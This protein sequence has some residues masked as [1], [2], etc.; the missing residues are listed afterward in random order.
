MIKI[1]S[2][3][4]Y[5]DTTK[6]YGDCIIF[7]D[8]AM[9][10]VYDCGSTEHAN[11][12]IEVLD[13][14][15]IEKATLVLSH[16]DDDH[17]LGIPTLIEAGR[18]DKLFTVLLLKYK[19]ELLD[20]IDDGRRNDDSIARAITD[21][22]DNITS[23]SKKVALRDVYEDE[24]E[25]PVQM[26]RIGPSFDYMI[27]AA[28]RGLDNREGNTIDNETITNAASVQIELTLG[29]SKV[30]LTGDCAPAAIPDDVQ[31]DAYGYIQLPHHG[32]PLLAEEIFLRT[33]DSND[34]TYFVSDNTGSSNGGS[35]NLDCKGRKIKNTKS[36]GE[37][38]F[39]A[40]SGSSS[41][42]GGS[43]GQ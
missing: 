27:K 37:L 3:K 21:L 16:N 5:E 31:L 17:F 14:H 32:K 30:L 39:Y 25:F 7:I 22:Y 18:V 23:L 2:S 36:D 38:T 41:Y 13:D 1:L 8:G 29:S 43:L 42:T 19:K 26:K 4:N 15:K 11:K 6:N 28:A 10:I 9:A 20:E 24:N 33:E 40:T 35:D 12:V 34:I